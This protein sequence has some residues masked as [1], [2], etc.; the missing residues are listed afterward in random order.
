MNTRIIG[1]G[2]TILRD[3]GAG[4]YAVREVGRR[5]K[6]SGARA[7]P[8]I[9]ESEAAGFALLEL[10]AG[11]ERVILVDSIQFDN[12]KAGT[13]IRIDPNDLRTS[14]KLRSIHEIDLPTALEV[15]RRLGFAMPRDVVVIGIQAEDARTFGES[16]SPAVALGMNE[17]VELIL[18]AAGDNVVG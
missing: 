12:L 9:V 7:R 8:D 2:N 14:L 18:Q 3:D 6:E 15:G 16:L 1:F 10:M 13:V 5:L 11:W 4:I 17:A